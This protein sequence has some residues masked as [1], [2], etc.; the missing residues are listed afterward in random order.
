MEQIYVSQTV[1]R[2]QK[3]LGHSNDGAA[4]KESI[5]VEENT[6]TNCN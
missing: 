3:R 1:Q 6:S 5:P 4:F 2:I